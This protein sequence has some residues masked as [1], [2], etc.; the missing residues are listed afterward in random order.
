MMS[1]DCKRANFVTCLVGNI[2]VK[3]I[4]LM[5]VTLLICSLRF[6]LSIELSIELPQKGR[7]SNDLKYR[8]YKDCLTLK[9]VAHADEY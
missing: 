6:V 8:R 7:L 1:C 5:D 2:S 3:Y 4:H 9:T